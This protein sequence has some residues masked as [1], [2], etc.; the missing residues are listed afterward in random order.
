[1]WL[2][3]TVV[4]FLKLEVK[5]PDPSKDAATPQKIQTGREE[6]SKIGGLDH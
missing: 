5:E 6:V 2:P 3:E 4:E 1:M